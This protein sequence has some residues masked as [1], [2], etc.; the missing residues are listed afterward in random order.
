MTKALVANKHHDL[1]IRLA[2][3][4]CSLQ[5][6]KLTNK[7]QQISSYVFDVVRATVPKLNLDD[8]F[9][10]SER[11]QPS[12]VPLANPIV[13]TASAPSVSAHKHP[14]TAFPY[15]EQVLMCCSC[16][17]L[18]CSAGEAGHCAL[19]QG[20][21]AAAF[22]RMSLSRALEHRLAAAQSA[23]V[24]TVAAAPGCSSG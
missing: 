14:A 16:A 18:L 5:F 12:C 20:G 13:D 7:H 10:V 11:R 3:C 6:Y 8:V 19:N 1:A 23:G 15:A 2:L 21:G 17:A 9:K 24:S 4:R 22:S